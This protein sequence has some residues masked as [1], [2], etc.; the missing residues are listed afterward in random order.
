VELGCDPLDPACDQRCETQAVSDVVPLGDVLSCRAASCGASCEVACGGILP[1]VPPASVASCAS[2]VASSCCAQASACAGSSACVSALE[3]AR[4]LSVPDGIEACTEVR[5]PTG[6]TAYHDFATC[7][8]GSCAEPCAIGA[9]WS[10]VGSVSVPVPTQA[11]IH[12][13]LTVVDAAIQ[14][15]TLPGLVVSACPIDDPA[16]ATPVASPVTTDA[17]GV[18]TLS[19]PT[20]NQEGQTGFVGYFQVVDPSP[21]GYG[22]T[23]GFSSNA[24]TQDG[25]SATI[26]AATPALAQSFADALNVTFNP[27]DGNLIVTEA[28][29]AYGISPDIQFTV[30]A[31]GTNV[32]V[33]YTQGG[34]PSASATKTDV[35]G[36][37]LAPN[38]PP[39]AVTVTATSLA[40][41]KVVSV[42]QIYMRAYTG[43]VLLL[44]PTP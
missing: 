4:G 24:I 22:T 21:G 43:T 12:F 29:C 9:D 27:N 18:A 7:V 44:T 38:I 17:N 28:D 41:G 6:T 3:C 33:Y 35:K 39:G 20:M 11:T 36:T 14:S 30:S 42:A 8:E 1:L 40:L 34:L 5:Y 13:S 31:A 15:L 16:C 23:L 32:P 25:A 26:I 19:L 37:G 10:C 2:C